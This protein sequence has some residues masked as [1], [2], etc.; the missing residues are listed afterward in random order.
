V[1]V[2][3]IIKSEPSTTDDELQRFLGGGGR[4][5]VWGCGRAGVRDARGRKRVVRVVDRDTRRR[6][7]WY[8]CVLESAR[9]TAGRMSATVNATLF[10]EPNGPPA[11]F[12]VY[13]EYGLTAAGCS[14]LL[15]SVRR[16]RRQADTR[17]DSYYMLVEWL[18]LLKIFDAMR[19]LV[20]LPWVS[21]SF[22]EW[23][24]PPPLTAI[25]QQTRLCQTLGF[26]HALHRLATCYLYFFLYAETHIVVSLDMGDKQVLPTCMRDALRLRTYGCLLFALTTGQLIALGY[27]FGFGRS[28]YGCAVI[29]SGPGGTFQSEEEWLR[30]KLVYGF[31]KIYVVVGWFLIMPASLRTIWLRSKQN[32]T[33][34]KL[35][36]VTKIWLIPLFIL[37]WFFPY[38][39][40]LPDLLIFVWNQDRV[41]GLFLSICFL[42]LNKRLRDELCCRSTEESLEQLRENT[43]R[44]TFLSVDSMAHS[45]RTSL[46]QLHRT[47][48]S[49]SK[50][51]VSPVPAD[52]SHLSSLG[53]SLLSS[54]FLTHAE[55][56]QRELPRT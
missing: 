55:S 14:L 45:S 52:P 39:I 56:H 42:T 11:P 31:T 21:F 24:P 28:Q 27:I 22:A 15:W 10:A 20:L 53:T 29:L 26:F 25:L 38:P 50:W 40:Q 2:V 8:S 30:Y 4:A 12:Y 13:L 33:N 32:A 43:F 47:S 51:G 3:A 49:R 54:N 17:I 9:A 23:Q 35:R 5:G 37:A 19:H 41:E 1:V 44:R 16:V 34:Q 7:V 6:S 18:M 46:F 36:V 48:G